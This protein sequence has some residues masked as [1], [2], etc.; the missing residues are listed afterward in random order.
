[1]FF[2]FFKKPKNLGFLKPNSTALIDIHFTPVSN[3]HLI[4]LP[5]IP[6]Y[7]LCSSNYAF[8]ESCHVTLLTLV[9]P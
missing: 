6:Y 8:S 1:M 7:T 5:I 3:I 9:S 4:T 2:R